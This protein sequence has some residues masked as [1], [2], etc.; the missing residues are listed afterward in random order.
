MCLERTKIEAV[1][2]FRNIVDKLDKERK[3]DNTE[4][5]LNPTMRLEIGAKL[6][7]AESSPQLT[8]GKHL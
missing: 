5:S 2:Q 3:R 6:E 1:L 4:T 7:L 8:S